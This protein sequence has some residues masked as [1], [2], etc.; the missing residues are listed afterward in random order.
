M[1]LPPI[2]PNPPDPY[3]TDPVPIKIEKPEPYN[4][5]GGLAYVW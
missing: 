3:P 1:T 2:A 4:P 5:Q